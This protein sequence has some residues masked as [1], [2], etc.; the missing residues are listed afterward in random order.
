[1]LEYAAPVRDMQFVIGEMIGYE[2]VAALAGC[3]E[4]NAEL[5]D[6]V[7]EEAAKF[8]AGVLAPLNRVGDTEGCRLDGDVVHTPAGWREAY[9]GF[10][11][12]GW[13]SLAMN[14]EFGGQGL[15]KLVATA[16][17]EMWDSA[18]MAF[19]LCPLLTNG[20]IE[21][22]EQHG[23][24]TLRERY[25]AKLVAGEW[26][27]T[28]NLTEPQAGSDLSAVRSRAEPNGDHYL[29]SGQKIFITY[30][31]HDLTDN[32]VHLVLARLPDAPEGTRG[33]SLFVVPKFLVNDD[34]SLGARN[35]LR[36]VSIEHKI[37]IHGSPTAVMSYGDNGGAVGYLVGEANRGLMYMFTMMNAARHAVGRE[38]VSIGEAA[39]QHA[40]KYARERVQGQPPGAS[41]RAPIV[42]HADV[43]RM[44]MTMKA[45]VEAMRALSYVCALAYDT[46]ELHPDDEVR[47][48]AT[49]RGD[50]LTPIVKGW[51]TETAQEIVSL[52][53]QVHGG[54]GFVEE[55]GAAQY[56][57]DARILPIYEGTTG[58][59]AGDLVGRKTLRDGGTAARE[60]IADME[61][62]LANLAAAD[63]EAAVARDALATGIVELRE[64]VEWL[65]A[66]ADDPQLGAAA[67]NHYLMLSGIVCGGWMLADAAGRAVAAIA[68]GSDDPCYRAK[69][70]AAAF[71]ATQIMP[72]A[73]GLKRMILDGAVVVA[74][75]DTAVL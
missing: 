48:R 14:P 36:C 50:L 30:G 46:A 25:L 29:I 60:L 53:V 27:G 37:G 54:M 6:A 33:I 58:I 45:Q 52:G 7:L 35:D 43:K 72:R 55:T 18:N 68:A 73:S 42:E 38:G 66:G 67:A 19:G 12:A 71:Y 63:G 2:R 28:M 56:F 70:A 64:V 44:L 11:E 23:D 61:L 49:R 39:F 15:P 57:R 41:E 31:E 5:V 34:G 17:S 1:M 59:Q 13:P 62:T 10:C 9:A 40:L 20:A 69:L 74:G 8:A 26:T 3:E 16:V 47:A 32:I 4:V 22:I 75:L 21:A 24:D 51:S 65:V